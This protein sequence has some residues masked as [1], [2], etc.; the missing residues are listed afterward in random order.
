MREHTFRAYRVVAV[1]VMVVALQFAV[2]SLS[3][4]YYPERRMVR[5]GNELFEGRN[6]RSSLDRYTSA[7]AADS[8]NYAALY[9]RANAYYHTLANGMADST[10]SYEISNQHF[11][12]IANDELLSEQQRAEV[13]RNLG[14]SLFGQERY[15]A[16]LNSFRQSLLLNPDDQECRY[17]YI[18]TKRIV[19]QKRA[20]E[21]Q[22]QEQQQNDQQN[23]GEDQ[24]QNDEQENGGDNQGEGEEQQQQNDEQSDQEDNGNDQS[25]SNGDDQSEEEDEDENP[26]SESDGDEEGDEQEQPSGAEPQEITADQERMLDAIQAEEDRTQDRLREAREALIRPGQKNW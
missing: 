1:V 15:E 9:N 16:A 18:L 24:Q 22:Q 17:D 26:E 2:N 6:Y 10:M 8:A 3:A 4:Q 14:Q 7:L 13:L 23:E 25:D 19:D 11:E 12:R 20:M 5:E 21:N